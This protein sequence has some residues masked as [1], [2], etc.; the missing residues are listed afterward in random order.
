MNSWWR[1]YILVDVDGFFHATYM[2]KDGQLCYATTRP[3]ME[4]SESPAEP[5]PGLI[6]IPASQ[7]FWIT[8]YSADARIYDPTGR[9]VLGKD[10]NPD[11]A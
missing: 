3:D 2:G 10:I 11:P 4:V 9:L 8:G 6:L 7:G 1:G 5:K